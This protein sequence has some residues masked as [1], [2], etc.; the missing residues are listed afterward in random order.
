M[1]PPDL[2]RS[3]ALFLDVDGTLLEIAARPE[4]V[5]VP[6]GL[7]DLLQR[8]SRQ[9]DGALAIVSGRSLQ[10]IDR[11][12]DPFCSSAAGEHG[13]ALRYA[14]GRVEDAPKG[15]SVPAEWRLALEA[16]AER[17]PGVRVVSLICTPSR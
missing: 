6:R 5:V 2:D 4:E 15:L 14:D 11:L 12:L 3:S 17:W 7:P 10:D 9:L 1:T 8:L 13:A 16:A